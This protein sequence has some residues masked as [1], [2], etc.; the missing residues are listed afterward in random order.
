MLRMFRKV[1]ALVALLGFA[2]AAQADAVISPVDTYEFG[3]LNSSRGVTVD[4]FS[5]E[6]HNLFSFVQG[7]YPATTGAIAGLITTGPLFASYKFGIDTG[8]GNDIHWLGAS[9]TVSVPMLDGHTF[10]AAVTIGGLHPGQKYWFELAGS[11]GAAE[12][13][14]TYTVTLAPVPEPESWALMLSGLGLM[15]FVVRRRSNLSAV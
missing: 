5:G 9:N 3:A 2:G 15:G 10:E 12:A 4:E 6:F 7:N 1:A 11:T 8:S 14:A 13:T